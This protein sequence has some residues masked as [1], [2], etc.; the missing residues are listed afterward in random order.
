[1]KADNQELRDRDM[2]VI[3]KNNFP[4]EH[5]GG[6][7]K[8][9]EK[10]KERYLPNRI[11]GKTGSNRADYSY[12]CTTSGRILDVNT[13]DVYADGETPTSREQKSAAQLEI[14]QET[15]DI[16][17]LIPKRQPG[18]KLNEELHERIM[19][20]VF[21]ELCREWTKGDPKAGTRTQKMFE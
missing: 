9:G 14:N 7:Y 11:T 2:A 16:T 1:V 6:V 12:R 4:I 13:V 19:T 18:E 17:M 3:K 5:I 21:D 8:D 20:K 15:G 10:V